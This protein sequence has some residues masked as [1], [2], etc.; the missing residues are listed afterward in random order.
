MYA[1]RPKPRSLNPTNKNIQVYNR[2]GG[3]PGHLSKKGN[4]WQNTLMDVD[5]TDQRAISKKL[6]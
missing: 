3:L 1:G 4:I 6:R 5:S 2:G